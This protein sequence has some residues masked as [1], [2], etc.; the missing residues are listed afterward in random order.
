MRRLAILGC[1][2]L[3]C[4]APA[5]DQLDMPAASQWYLPLMPRPSFRAT[6]TYGLESSA[7]VHGQDA[8]LGRS[9][10]FAQASVRMFRTDDGEA[11]LRLSG[12]DV[13]LDGAAALPRTGPLPGRLQDA[14]IGGFVRQVRGDGG[15]L[16][17]DAELSSPSDRPYAGSD[18]LSI[19]ATA[20]A[21]IP[22]GEGSGWILGL[23]YDS[24]RSFLPGVPLPF[25]A[26]RL[27]RPDDG[28]TAMIGLPASIDWIPTDGL[29]LSAG[30]FPVDAVRSEATWD[31]ALVR[32]RPWVSGPWAIQAGAAITYE[33]WLRSGREDSDAQL[34]FRTVRAYAAGEWRPFPGSR[35]RLSAGR[36]LA[37]EVYET[38]SWTDRGGN[39]LETGPAW[40]GAVSATT[41]F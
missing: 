22:A 37:R 2:C 7:P 32:G 1:V 25:A 17:L 41:G 6:S 10:G 13:R 33:D 16:G 18:V 14:R 15:V 34:T 40:Y 19:S 26:Y 20:F 36:I 38:G 27:S 11:W 5:L 31:P 21:S 4:G 3:A 24:T 8:S 28:L 30:W 9:G 29:K 35:I 39:R 12:A 23:R